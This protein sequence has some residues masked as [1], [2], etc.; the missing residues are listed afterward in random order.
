MIRPAA[1][2]KLIVGL[3][4]GDRDLLAEAARRLGHQLGALD[5]SSDVHPFVGTSY[6]EDELGTEVW[7]QFLSTQELIRIDRLPEIKRLTNDLEFRFCDDLA[8]SHDKRPINLDPGYLTLSKLVLATTKD[9][10]HRLYLGQGIFGEVTLHFESG[11]WKAWPW[12]YPDYA[13]KTY[14]GW[15][16]ATRERLKSQLREP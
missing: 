8:L 1:K 16:T 15:L 12:T 3:L 2:A 13:T 4:S 9:Y 5:S 6:Y 11:E 7:R 14:H 10:S